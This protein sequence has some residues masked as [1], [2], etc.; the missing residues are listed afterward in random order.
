MSKMLYKIFIVIAPT[1]SKNIISA[2]YLV[3]KIKTFNGSFGD[4]TL[5]IISPILLSHKI[6]LRKAWLIE[7]KLRGIIVSTYCSSPREHTMDAVRVPRR[8][9]PTEAKIVPFLHQGI[10][11]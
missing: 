1:T 11:R 3:T 6:I 5:K 9:A 8:E 7:T 4:H 10:P 2:D